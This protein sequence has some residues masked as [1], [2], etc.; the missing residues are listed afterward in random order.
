MKEKT[1]ISSATL[2]TSLVAYWYAKAAGKDAAPLVML[3]G[4]VGSLIGEGIA[5]QVKKKEKK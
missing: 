2:L 4:F 3:G 5:D 1:I